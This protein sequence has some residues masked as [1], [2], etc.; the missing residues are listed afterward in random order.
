MILLC[1][2]I[3]LL[4]RMMLRVAVQQIDGMGNQIRHGIERLYRTPG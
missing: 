4:I 3:R 1:L 2:W